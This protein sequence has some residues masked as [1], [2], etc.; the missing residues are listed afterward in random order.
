M[1]RR[2]R[3]IG[4]GSAAVLVVAGV[5]GAIVVNGTPGQVLAIVL[6]ALGLV[7]ATALVFL[8]VGLSED[9][10]RAREEARRRRQSSPPAQAPA[11]K[12]E[13]GARPRLE[14]MRGSRRKLQ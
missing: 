8:E 13:R 10:E 11:R 7:L 2:S 9:R 3:I 6:I 5:V 12:E 14:R 1:S 4:F